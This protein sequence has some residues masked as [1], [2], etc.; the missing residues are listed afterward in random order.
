MTK[1]NSADFLLLDREDKNKKIEFIKFS[2]DFI[3]FN[4]YFLCLLSR[5]LIE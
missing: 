3:F 4:D 2:L 5:K 1:E